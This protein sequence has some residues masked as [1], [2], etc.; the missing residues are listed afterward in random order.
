M[1]KIITVAVL[2][3][4]LAGAAVAQDGGEIVH[5]VQEGENLYRIAL[6][7]GVTVAAILDA[8]GLQS[9]DQILAGQALVIPG[10]WEPEP[11]QSPKPAWVI[12]GS[13]QPAQSPDEAPGTY[14]VQ[15][16]DTVYQ[17][18][19]RF[20]VSPA[21]I[22]ALNALT[23]PNRILPGEKIHIPGG[24]APDSAP[25][26][27]PD[28]MSAEFLS[29]LGPELR[30][31]YARGLEKGS[32]PGAFSKVGDCNSE[33][34]FFLAHFDDG[35]YDLG[36]YADLQ[37]AIDHCAGSFER[38]SVA[39]W[40]G[41]HA[42]AVLDP[43]WADP[44]RCQ[45]GETPL[46]CEF[47]IHRPSFVFIRLGTNDTGNAAHFRRSLSEIVAFSIAEGVIPI[48]GTKPDR[49][50]GS[51]A[52]NATIREIAAEYG[53]PLW[54]FDRVAAQSGSKILWR[55]G[56]HMYW[57]PGLYFDNPS[58]LRTGHPL[59]NLTALIALDT[60]WRAVTD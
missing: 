10:A 26:A 42:W 9:A 43:F 12:K 31:I 32:N 3:I 19:R 40:T 38:E 45:P 53:V 22:I 46:A 17:I 33:T 51:N 28:L 25:S 54:D 7:Y 44:N 49:Y 14:T 23:N 16:G 57:S 8:N 20:D 48:L 27:D 2:F 5:V 36:A 6:R 50:E 1:R 37:P 56:V 39:V 13:A 35:Q 52:N 24:S 4:W 55:D 18:A 11:P 59:H 58:A 29:G 21:D 41:N 15:Q 34:P 30:E 60:V 47:R